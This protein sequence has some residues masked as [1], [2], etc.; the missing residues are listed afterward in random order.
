MAQQ[1]M[2]HQNK[3]GIDFSLSPN[4]KNPTFKETTKRG[5]YNNGIKKKKRHGLTY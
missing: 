4:T 2:Q 1:K 5:E 3:T